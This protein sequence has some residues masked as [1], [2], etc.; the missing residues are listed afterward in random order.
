[1]SAKPLVAF[2]EQL[3]SELHQALARE[4]SAPGNPPL[5]VSRLV[6]NIQFSADPAGEGGL[7]FRPIHTGAASGEPGRAVHGVTIEL[8]APAARIAHPESVPA[9]APMP[10]EAMASIARLVPAPVGKPEP[11]QPVPSGAGDTAT[12]R[13]RCEL[14]LGGPPGFTT[15]ARAEILCDL[16]SEFGPAALLEVLRRDWITQFDT[17][18]AASESVTKPQPPPGEETSPGNGAP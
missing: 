5:T 6:L 10:T 18:P 12:L 14:V 16:L 1:M 3:R 17:G 11:A 2:V 13:R 15:G 7:V 9:I 4:E 8:T